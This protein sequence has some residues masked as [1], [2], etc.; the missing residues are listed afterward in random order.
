MK[1]EDMAESVDKFLTFNEFRVLEGKGKITKKKAD[2]KALKEY[3]E[4]NKTQKI[5]S[6][7]DKITKEL[8]KGNEKV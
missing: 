6:D 4:F 5:E 1:M 2:E 3:L 7:F 8:L